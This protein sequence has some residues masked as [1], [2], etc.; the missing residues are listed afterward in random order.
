M[1]STFTI[2]R[3]LLISS[4][5]TM[6]LENEF[7]LAGNQNKA[8]DQCFDKT[9]HIRA[10]LDE[11]LDDKKS[12]NQYIKEYQLKISS[13]SQKD[14]SIQKRL[15]DCLNK[16]GSGSNY[17][18]VTTLQDKTERLVKENDEY[19]QEI[20]KLIAYIK[21]LENK[22]QS[23][24]DS[25]MKK[26]QLQAENERLNEQV[27]NLNM[28]IS[29]LQSENQTIRANL[30]I[31]PKLK[32]TLKTQDKR[33]DKAYS[34][35]EKCEN[36]VINVE[37]ELK[38]CRSNQ[39][40]I[41]RLNQQVSQLTSELQKCESELQLSDKKLDK[42][43]SQS[44]DCKLCKNDMQKLLNVLKTLQKRYQELQD[45]SKQCKAQV[46]QLNIRITN[47]EQK[48][49]SDQSKCSNESDK[50]N[51][52]TRELHLLIEKLKRKIT[53]LKSSRKNCK[54]TNECNDEL[55]YW[56]DLMGQCKKDLIKISSSIFD[57]HKQKDNP[58]PNQLFIGRADVIS[59]IL[60]SI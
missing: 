2:I 58:N 51:T 17:E 37:N 55:N 33:L 10:K 38:Q 44:N 16:T 18:E 39:S 22:G 27:N 40:N 29:D 21:Q 8:K 60:I 45:Q 41:D 3:L 48:I 26:S 50:I 5:L 30:S 59:F 46:S 28:Q 42:C 7:S 35:L 47:L 9:H 4:T 24:G 53:K 32:E 43:R 14:S 34:I 54:A 49:N 11:C 52:E 19:R 20:H 57:S 1:K 36:Q 12:L 31:I 25:E 6:S 23:D 56:K 13:L 15:N